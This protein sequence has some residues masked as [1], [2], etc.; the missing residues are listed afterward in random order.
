MSSP[1]T[2]PSTS[3]ASPSDSAEIVPRAQEYHYSEPHQPPGPKQKKYKTHAGRNRFGCGGRL[4]CSR[5]HGA[6]VV[7]VF[8]MI[9]TLTLYFVF[10]APF[11]WDYSPAIPIVAA[12]FSI[13]VISNFVATSFTDPGILPR[14]ENIEIIEMDRQMGMTNGHTNDPNVQRP[15]FRDVIINGEH[16]KMKYCTTCRLYR[17]PRCSHCAI[18]DNCVLMFDHHCPWVGNCIGLRNYTYFYR[19]VFCLSIL[20]IY[21]F[22]CAVTHMSLLAQQMP[23]GEVMR[24]TP[25]SVV[26]IVV[27]FLTTW[28]IIGLACFHTYLLCADLTTN[29][30]LKGLYRKKHRPTPPSSN[31]SVNPGNPTKNPFYTGCL[32][33]FAGRLF[34]S[35]F[36]SVLDATGFVDHQPTIEIRVPIEHFTEKSG[37][38]G[39]K[40]SDNTKKQPTENV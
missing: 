23:F 18:C 26:V 8:L 29:E 16:V 35:R 4:V 17:P 2:S 19:F 5:S 36:P 40:S 31:A 15:R 28:S 1:V 21:L 7:T 38:N 37:T 11:L 32:K 10:D 34:K 12:V 22:A 24:K 14:V 27:C 39:E 30:D 6:F 3:S 33:S 9:A 13:T 25:G 20:V